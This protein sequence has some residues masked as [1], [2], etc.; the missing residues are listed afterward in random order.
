M[1]PVSPLTTACFSLSSSPE[2]SEYF[3]FFADVREVF[4]L[5]MELGLEPL[6]G[7][8]SSSLSRWARFLPLADVGVLGAREPA[9][10]LEGVAGLV[11]PPSLRLSGW[12]SLKAFWIVLDQCW[13][14]GSGVSSNS[15][16]NERPCKGDV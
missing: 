7:D 14:V 3:N 16:N 12:R 9:P 4:F 11:S 13:A 8:V 15:W 5:A 1:S 2:S 6:S 10:A